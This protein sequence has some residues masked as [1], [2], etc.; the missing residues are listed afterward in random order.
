M[1]GVLNEFACMAEHT[2]STGRTDPDDLVGLSVWLANTIVGPVSRDDGSTPFGAFQNASQRLW[3][4]DD[5][6]ARPDFSLR[7]D[8]QVVIIRSGSAG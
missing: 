2:I 4:A 3:T 1:L 8:D 5:T 7:A 6:P